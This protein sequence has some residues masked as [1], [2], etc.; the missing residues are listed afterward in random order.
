MFQ[1]TVLRASMLVAASFFGFL[2]TP[3]CV[4]KIGPGSN[5]GTGGIASRDPDPTPIDP[6]TAD[7]TDAE[8]FAAVDPQALAFAST[9]ATVT[10]SALHGMID[11]LPLDPAS[12]D[13]ATV[14]ALMEQYA[15]AAA[16]QTD[17]WLAST[18]P[19]ML[20]AGVIAKDSC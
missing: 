17:L 4:I 20:S 19:S 16:E 15:P 5:G 1:D 3:A 10:T 11:A 14:L 9:K 6:P 12:L 7:E 18:D 8:L 13:D 2:M